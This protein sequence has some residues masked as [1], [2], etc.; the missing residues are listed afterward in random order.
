MKKGKE[1]KREREA[2]LLEELR[3]RVDRE[4]HRERK[5]KEREERRHL[6]GS[7]HTCH[8]PFI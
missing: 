1:R 4:I 5:K 2:M 6:E 8:I 7:G 3:E